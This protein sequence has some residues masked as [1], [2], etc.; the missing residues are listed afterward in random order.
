VRVKLSVPVR[1]SPF[2]RCRTF[3]EM[4]NPA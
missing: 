4:N 3:S 1:Q 2:R